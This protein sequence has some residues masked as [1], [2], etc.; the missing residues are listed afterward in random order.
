MVRLILTAIASIFAAAPALADVTAEQ[1]VEKEI[2]RRDASGAESV[3]R[4]KADTVVPGEEIIYSLRFVNDANQAAD[5][6]VLVMPVPA[7]VKYVE[8]S[9]TGVNARV[10]FSADGGQTYVARGRLT[11]A[12]DGVQRPA[13]S[14]EISH[15]K[16]TL[17]EPL[18]ANAKGEVAYR[19]VLK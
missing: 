1:I 17:L 7:E 11:V 5:A 9:V 4:V 6:I 19:A 2:I 16:W 13:K 14:D 10:T 3:E 8:G 18:A 12:E 15:I